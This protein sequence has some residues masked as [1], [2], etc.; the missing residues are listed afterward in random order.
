MKMSTRGRSWL[1]LAF[2]SLAVSARAHDSGAILRTRIPQCAVYSLSGSW[3]PKELYADHVLRFTYLC[4]PP[5]KNPG[6][7][8][9]PD[10][11]HRVYAAF[12][13][14]D[15]TKGELLRFVWLRR[16]API[17]LRIVNNGHIV[18]EHGKMDIE[19]ALWGVWTHEHLMMRLARLQT[20]PLQIVPV[21]EIPIRGAICDSYV[22]A[23][24][25]SALPGQP[26][27]R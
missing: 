12:W 22:H 6:E 8:D 1:V 24:G 20:A 2:L 4:E 18:R 10:N 5:K 17:Q 7:Y 13:N 25:D 11:L 21:R 27:P 3:I 19:D 15:R 9:Y 14:R 23:V 26:K 16:T